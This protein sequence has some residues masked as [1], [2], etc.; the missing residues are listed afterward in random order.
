MLTARSLL[1]ARG[2]GQSP[3]GE[4]EKSKLSSHRPANCKSESKPGYGGKQQ[5]KDPE[6]APVT[7]ERGSRTLELVAWE[8]IGSVSRGG[9]QR[10]KF[11]YG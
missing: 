4:T 5:E 1:S 6:A 11:P 7:T 2:P 9:K 8:I 3:A 10:V